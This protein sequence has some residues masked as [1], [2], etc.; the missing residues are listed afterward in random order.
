MDQREVTA[1]VPEKKDAEGKVVQEKLGPVSILVDFPK[2]Y[3]ESVGWCSEEAMI[4]NAFAQFRVSP[5]QA[6]I[7]TMLKAG[8]TQEEIQ[9]ALGNTVMGVARAGVKVDTKAAYIALFKNGTPEEQA[10]MLKDLRA[11]AQGK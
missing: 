11:E 2:S 10:Q 9:A 3:E 1:Q 7:R 5:I 4:S 8:K 6:G